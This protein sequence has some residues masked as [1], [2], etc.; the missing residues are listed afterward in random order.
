MADEES[1]TVC[2][3]RRLYRAFAESEPPTP[4]LADDELVALLRAEIQ[5]EGPVPATQNQPDAEQKGDT[6]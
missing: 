1:E 6:S 4:P 5:A 3:L 2:E